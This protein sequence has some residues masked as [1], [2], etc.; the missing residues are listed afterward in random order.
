[1]IANLG[2]L[3]EVFDLELMNRVEG[4]ARLFALCR[5]PTCILASALQAVT[6]GQRQSI[7]IADVDLGQSD[8]I[9]Q[10]PLAFGWRLIVSA[11][12]SHIDGDKVEIVRQS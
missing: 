3:E 5:L 2:D 11:P 10:A 7:H 8:L 9:L 12:A 4:H 6:S 1:V